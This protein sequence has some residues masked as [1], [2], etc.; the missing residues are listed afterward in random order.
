MVDLTLTVGDSLPL[1]TCRAPVDSPF[2]GPATSMTWP[3][4]SD[5]V[6]AR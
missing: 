3:G 1:S 2:G 5:R 6:P 4:G